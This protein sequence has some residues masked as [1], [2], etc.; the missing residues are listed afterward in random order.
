MLDERSVLTVLVSSALVLLRHASTMLRWVAV[1]ARP[2]HSSARARFA[3][4]MGTIAPAIRRISFPARFSIH[5]VG[6]SPTFAYWRKYAKVGLRPTS[7]LRSTISTTPFIFDINI[8]NKLY[9]NYI[10]I[11]ILYILL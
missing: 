1:L 4:G 11:I 10:I 5:L 6:R 9:I 2:S 3:Q 7:I 8:L